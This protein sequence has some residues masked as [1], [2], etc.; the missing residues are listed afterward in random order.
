MK[1]IYIVGSDGSGTEYAAS[2]EVKDVLTPKNSPSQCHL[3]K[4]FL[5]L[6][7]AKEYYSKIRGEI[8]IFLTIGEVDLIE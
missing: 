7:E 2:I 5:T 6:E 4:A 8:G 1:K 3:T